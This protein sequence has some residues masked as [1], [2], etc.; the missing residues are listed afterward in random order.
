MGTIGT[1]VIVVTVIGII[2][3]VMLSVASK[4]MAVK[5]DERI[6]LVRESKISYVN[7]HKYSVRF[8]PF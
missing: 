2:C 1:A 6:P 4:V 3:A 5:V 8:S 7:L